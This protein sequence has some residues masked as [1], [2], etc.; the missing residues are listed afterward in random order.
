[1]M[2]YTIFLLLF[3]YFGKSRERYLQLSKNYDKINDNR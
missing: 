1:M 3:F 2:L